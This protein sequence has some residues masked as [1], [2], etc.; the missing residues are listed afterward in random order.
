MAKKK[1]EDV[2]KRKGS[3]LFDEVDLKTLKIF[4]ILRIFLTHTKKLTPLL[5]IRSRILSLSSSDFRQTQSIREPAH[6][7][8]AKDS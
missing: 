5:N 6:L 3:I 2:G 7:L 1:G 8:P 4:L